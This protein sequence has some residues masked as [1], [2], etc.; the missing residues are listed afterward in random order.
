LVQY[1][2]AER[3]VLAKRSKEKKRFIDKLRRRKEF[4]N[5]GSIT[6]FLLFSPEFS[7]G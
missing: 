5:S 1:D 4:P 7:E 3:K 2:T 6:L